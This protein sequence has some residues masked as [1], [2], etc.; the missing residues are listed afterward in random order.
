[1]P[2]PLYIQ[3]I[4]C[5][6]IGGISMSGLAEI[7]LQKGLHVTG[8][9][10]QAN[11][12]TK[13]LIRLGAHITYTHQAHA[14]GDAQALV[15]SNAVDPHNPERLAAK[16][17]GIPSWTRGQLLG[18]LF[19][20]FQGISVIGSHGKT[21]TTALA[22]HALKN[23]GMEL[24]YMIGGQLADQTPHAALGSSPWFVSE[25]DESDAS[26]TELKPCV[27]V[28]TN[29]E[30]DHM[31]TYG[32]S[33]DQLKNTFIDFLN[34]LPNHGVAIVCVDDP[35]VRS[36]LPLLTCPILTYGY[37]PTAHY[38]LDNHQQNGLK[39]TFTITHT[40]SAQQTHIHLNLPGQ[41]NTQNSA[42]VYVLSQ[43]LKLNP[44]KVSESLAHFP[45]VARRFENHGLIQVT[46]PIQVT[47]LEDYGHHPSEIFHT[48][49]AARSAFPNQR[50]VVVF[51]PHRYTRTQEFLTEFAQVLSTCDCLIL[52][53]IYAAS[54]PKIPGITGHTLYQAVCQIS[55]QKPKYVGP[56][57]AIP[58]LLQ[59]LSQDRDVILFQGAGSIG[60]Q[61][62]TFKALC[63]AH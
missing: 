32:H 29:L 51:Q 42:G 14:L 9:D 40:Q 54:E 4:H 15:Y 12:L 61:V 43:Y 49:Q 35:M 3:H 36:L 20:P 57:E 39:S 16:Q 44:K 62:H 37:H 10:L 17:A 52:C 8:T 56:I 53:D 7:L 18:L 55:P 5:T 21:T 13:R 59:R 26:F 63:H 38:R 50:L 27:V 23:S 45:G 24:S 33:L 58:E 22:V 47:V 2:L 6:G 11:T 19:N 41:Y 31:S 30:A 28:L 1:M 25:A 46:D 60:E 48:L 34:T